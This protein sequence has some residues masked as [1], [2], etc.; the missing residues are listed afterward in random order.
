[1]LAALEEKLL[2]GSV[3]RGKNRFLL[4]SRSWDKDYL[5][6]RRTLDN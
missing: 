3:V 4:S 6:V 1:M 5:S 2:A